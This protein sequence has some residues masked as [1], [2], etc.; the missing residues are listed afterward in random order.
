[1]I[2]R[3][4]ADLVLIVHLGFVLFVVLGGLLVWRWSWLVGIHLAAVSWG[5]LIEFAGFA[6]PLTPL[7]DHLRELGGEVGYEGDFIGH[8]ITEFLYPAG[9][10][11]SLQIWLGSLALLSNLLIYGYFLVRKVREAGGQMSD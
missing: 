3:L 2:Y 6:C 4:S 10:T 11:R 8:Y 7:E 1:M 9:L 5:A